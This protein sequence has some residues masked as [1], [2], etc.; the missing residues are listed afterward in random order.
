MS[1]NDIM[2]Q[3]H[4]LKNARES[5]FRLPL[6]HGQGIVMS[7]FMAAEHKMRRRKSAKKTPAR[8]G[9]MRPFTLDQVT[10]LEALLR[11]DGSGTAIRDLALLRVGMDSTLRS[12]DV[13]SLTVRDV[14]QN[15]EVGASFQVK[16]RE[17]G[18]AR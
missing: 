16:Q 4:S 3:S 7:H 17:D 6:S 10:T 12:S 9:Q 18:Q 11:Q 8:R 15:G 14:R 13:L 2:R 5:M 1:Q